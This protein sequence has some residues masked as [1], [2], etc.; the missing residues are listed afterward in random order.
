M[1]TKY[2]L[3]TGG[4][5]YIGSHTCKAVRQAARTPL[6]V[7]NLVH[8]HRWAVQ[9]G[10]L[11]VGDICDSSLLDH[12][13]ERYR[14]DAVVHFAAYAYVGESVREPA[15]YY[16]NNVGGTLTLIDA[17][18]RHNCRRLVFSS[19]CATYGT[20]AE[21]PI[22]ESSPQNPVNPYGRSKWVIEQ[23]LKDY[24]AAYGMRFVSLRYFNA[25]GA[26]PD[27]E[28]GEDHHPETH[29]I[30]LAMDTALGFRTVLEIY[31]NDYDTEDGTAIRDYVHVSDLADT[32]VRAIE[33]L[34]KGG[35]SCCL[36]LGT[37]RGHSVRQ[38]VSA[39]EKVSGKPVNTKNAPRRPG[40]P[41]VLYADANRAAEKMGWAPRFSSL[42]A[43]VASA[44]HWHRRQK[45]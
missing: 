38:V 14:P 6:V 39:V 40:D 26:D 22:D 10:P 8:G 37:G 15:K 13:F 34:G 11:I 19:S 21:M 43:I 25:A 7:D 35:A 33:Y 31:G 36:N 45:A 12:V 1:P 29:L 30:P 42:E 41:A 2:I 20:P 28:L 24:E 5:G 32:H 17:M 4:A 16:H 44:W 23:I 18:Q 3:V 27:G 9:W